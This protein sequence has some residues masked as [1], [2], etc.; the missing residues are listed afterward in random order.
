MG[1]LWEDLLKS[2]CNYLYVGKKGL[3]WK[4]K[5]SGK[6]ENYFEGMKSRI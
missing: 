1:W 2:Y 4:W 5:K 6:Y 3:V